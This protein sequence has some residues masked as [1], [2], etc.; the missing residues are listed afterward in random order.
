MAGITNKGKYLSLGAYECE[1]GRTD[2]ECYWTYQKE[3]EGD[4]ERTDRPAP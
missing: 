3:T 2:K 1:S 4:V